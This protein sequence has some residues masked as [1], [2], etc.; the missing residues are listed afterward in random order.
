MSS[1]NYLFV[2]NINGDFDDECPY[3]TSASCYESWDGRPSVDVGG[4]WDGMTIS[5]ELDVYDLPDDA[6]DE[7]RG[8]AWGI[9]LNHV[10]SLRSDFLRRD[11]TPNDCP[12]FSV[13]I[14]L[15]E[16]YVLD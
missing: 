12:D 3:V 7:A 1:N 15:I 4:T 5:E 2:F 10:E 14:E 8:D 11:C 9:F 13:G 16:A 6:F